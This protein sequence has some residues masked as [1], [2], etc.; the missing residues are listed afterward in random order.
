MRLIQNWQYKF[1]ERCLY[2]YKIIQLSTSTTDRKMIQAINE[3]QQFFKGSSH[4]GMMEYYYFENKKYRKKYTNAGHFDWVCRECLYMEP[5]N[6]WVIRREIIYRIA[7]NCYAL[8][9][10]RLKVDSI[11]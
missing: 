9:L 6:G 1:I 5:S 11:K 4:A 8:G 10:F 2:D 7:M 3:A